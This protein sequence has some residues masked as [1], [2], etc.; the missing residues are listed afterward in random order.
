LSR[1]REISLAIPE[2]VPL[3]NM[4]DFLANANIVC[5]SIGAFH[6]AAGVSPYRTTCLPGGVKSARFV[7]FYKLN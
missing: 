4:C 7:D 6:K 1:F 3:K 2:T 5:E